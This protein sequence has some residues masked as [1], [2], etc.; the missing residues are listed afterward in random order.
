MNADIMHGLTASFELGKFLCAG[1]L[2]V[3]AKVF[4]ASSPSTVKV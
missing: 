2:Y 1:A 4:L 3:E